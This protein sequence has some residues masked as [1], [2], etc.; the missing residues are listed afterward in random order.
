M[1]DRDRVINQAIK[2]C[3]R[4]MYRKAQPRGNYDQYRRQI[5]NGEL[6]SDTK[7]YE[8]HYLPQA[9]FEYILNKYIKAYKICDDWSKDVKFII[10]EIKLPIKKYTTKEDTLDLNYD[11]GPRTLADQIGEE[12]KN[13]VIKYLE[14]LL[15]FYSF[16]REQSIFRGTISLGCSPTSNPK[17]V[18]DYW[19]SQGVEVEIDE[20]ENLTEEDYWRM[21][22]YGHVLR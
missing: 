1:L 4:E 7:I 19:K 6:S 14:N 21:D 3:L 8:R 22:Y 20:K 16:D 9:E 5:E 18:K 17:T 2:D 13:K 10:D 12:N 15:N 11:Q